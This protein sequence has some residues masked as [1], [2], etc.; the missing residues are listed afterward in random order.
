VSFLSSVLE[1]FLVKNGFLLPKEPIV[2]ASSSPPSSRKRKKLEKYQF[3]DSGY[4]E[5]TSIGESSLENQHH[6]LVPD[7]STT[8]FTTPVS[9][10]TSS[11]DHP[12]A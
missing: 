6:M 4:A 10:P 12:N 9:P 8:F 3:D 1:C 11:A 5:Q 7:L 2:Q